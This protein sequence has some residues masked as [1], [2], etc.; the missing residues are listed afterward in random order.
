MGTSI[1]D[2]A[3]TRL[4]ASHPLLLCEKQMAA[5][6][7]SRRGLLSLLDGAKMA[8]GLIDGQQIVVA[9]LEDDV[10]KLMS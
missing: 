3:I 2:R 10:A 4:H 8:D 1:G 7:L 9:G 6:L 5:A